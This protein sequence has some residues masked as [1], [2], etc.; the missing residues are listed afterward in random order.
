MATDDKNNNAIRSQSHK[1]TESV[2]YQTE[3]SF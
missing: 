3:Q 1:L 2:S